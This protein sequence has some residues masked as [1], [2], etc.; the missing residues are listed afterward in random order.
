[1][2]RKKTVIA[3]GEDL[4]KEL[5]SMCSEQRDDYR[6]LKHRLL[7]KDFPESGRKRLVG[8]ASERLT[9]EDRQSLLKLNK[10]HTDVFLQLAKAYGYLQT[11]RAHSG[12]KGS[13]EGKAETISLGDLLKRSKKAGGA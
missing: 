12:P 6:Q 10:E 11:V 3:N 5:L 1:M 2:A 4:E 13:E 8:V 7:R 9:E